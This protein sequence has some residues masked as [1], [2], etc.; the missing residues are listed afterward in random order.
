MRNL[1]IYLCLFLV[2]VP[3][4]WQFIP[5]QSETSVLGLPLWVLVSILGSACVS[6]H[7]ALILRNPW[8]GE[9][10]EQA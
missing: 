6:I 1:I 3:W 4:Y 8:P 9:E 5:W 10:G 2:G 7:T